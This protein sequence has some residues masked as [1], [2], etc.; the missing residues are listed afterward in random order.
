MTT[1]QNNALVA[2][3]VTA[4]LRTGNEIIIERTVTTERVTIRPARSTRCSRC[5]GT[6]FSRGREWVSCS[7]CGG[8]GVIK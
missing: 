7:E 4:A 5:G 1:H 2:I 6:G 3:A 8:S